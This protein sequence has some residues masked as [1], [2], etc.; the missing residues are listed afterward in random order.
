VAATIR[1]AQH[2]LH[3]DPADRQ[4]WAEL[5][6]SY[7]RQAGRTGDPT[8]Y[9]KAEG[10]LK[11]SLA[12]DP[13]GNWQAM[14]GLGALAN[15]RNDFARGLGWAQRADAVNPGNAL[16]LDTLDDARTQL[17]APSGPR[18]V[19]PRGVLALLRSG[20]RLAQ[21]GD[22]TSA[23]KALIAALDQAVEGPDTGSCRYWLGELAF[24]Q[25]DPR[26]ALQDYR[27][28]LRADP[29]NHRLLAGRAKAE[30][31]LGRKGAAQHDYLAAIALAP[32]PEYLLAYAELLLSLGRDDQA[33]QQLAA[34]S[35]Q[36]RLRAAN[37]VLD[38]LTGATV[39]ADH[40][41]ATAAVRQAE[42]EWGRRQS[43]I[44]ADALGWA[45][46]RAGRDHEAL[47]YATRANRFGG[48]NAGFRY[49]LGM[50]ELA[51]DRRADARRDLS[52]ALQLNPYFSVLQAPLARRA[53]AATGP[54][55]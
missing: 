32:Q 7:L 18:L 6:G 25:G 15:A 21:R 42:A 23:R 46:H 1:R 39:E 49:H 24:D 13:A 53:L 2:R 19:A 8:Y 29:G 34:L 14:A 30:A 54:A 28:G 52:A 11:R 55:R 22:P 43:V 33:G 31:A 37:G 10:A 12:L 51:L 40:G 45:L 5:G 35:E 4:T 20:Y 41:S 44:V 38:D 36:R 17:G 3:D 47:R 16:V 27:L 26:I 9:P 48:Q 50:I